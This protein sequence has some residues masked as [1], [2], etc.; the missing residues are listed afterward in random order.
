MARDLAAL[1]L[2][3]LLAPSPPARD[4]RCGAAAPCS[5]DPPTPGAAPAAARS[6][7]GR[8]GCRRRSRPSRRPPG[9]RARRPARSPR[10]RGASAAPRRRRASGSPA[11][12][13]RGRRPPRSRGSGAGCRGSSRPARRGSPAPPASGPDLRAPRSWSRAGTPASPAAERGSRG[14]VHERELQE[15]PLLV[16]LGEQAQHALGQ[17]FALQRV[18]AERKV[19]AVHLERR[20]GDEHD[21]ALAVEPIELLLGER[22]PAQQPGGHLLVLRIPGAQSRIGMM[23]ATISPSHAASISAIA[24]RLR[25]AR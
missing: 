14:R 6:P 24:S 3:R 1:R 20:A 2:G 10:R 23:A 12:A 19:R 5:P 15:G 17:P 25:D 16:P 11:R 8:R 7:P 18:G 22:L 13:R 9:G 21:G 4:R